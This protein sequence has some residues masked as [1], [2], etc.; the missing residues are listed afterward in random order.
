MNSKI[1]NL[2]ELFSDV[3]G[4]SENDFDVFQKLIDSKTSCADEIA[5]S[6]SKDKSTVQR[7]LGRLVIAG[8]VKRKS[9]CLCN[10]KKGRFFAYAAV[11]KR[12]LKSIFEEKLKKDFEEKISVVESL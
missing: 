3:L 1:N 11:E 4:L 7:S 5:K 12:A 10:G 2:N 9:V 6:L 8:V